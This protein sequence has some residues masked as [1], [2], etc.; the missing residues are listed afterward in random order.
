[1]KT[2]LTTSPQVAAAFIRAGELAAFPTE[3]VYGLGADVF[4]PNAVEKIYEAKGRPV[5]NP[6]I[7]HV[8]E[9]DQVDAVAVDVPSYA[10]RLIDRLFPGPLT[11]VLRKSPSIPSI[12]TS[13]L[14]T[15]AV[16]MPDHAVARSFLAACGTAVAAPSANRS[17]RP[18]PTTWQAVFDDLDGHISCI[19]KGERAAFGLEST[20]VDCTEESPIVLRSGAVSV[21]RIRNVVASVRAASRADEEA[22]RSPGLRHRHYAPLARVRPV[23]S[24]PRDPEARSAYIGTTAPRHPHPYERILVCSDTREYAYELFDFFRACDAAGIRT[25]YCELPAPGGLGTALVDRL[26]RASAA[27]DS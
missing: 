27:A 22:G 26:L 19:L 13:G 24:A 17:G 14:D 1:M 5:D 25:I 9:M 10:R 8:S 20:V 16:R 21:E 7:V 18:S 15:V 11:L 6:L 2:T 23:Q 4:R 3:T 12:V